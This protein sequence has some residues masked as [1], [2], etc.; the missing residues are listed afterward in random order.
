MEGASLQY[1]KGGITTMEEYLQQLKSFHGSM[2][3]GL[4]IGG[5]MVKLALRTLPKDKLYDAI[6]ETPLCL[7]D[8]IQLLTPC[9]IGNGW[10]TVLNFGRF[11]ITLYDKYSGVG[12][13]VYLD[14]IKLKKYPEVNSWYFK[15]KPKSEQDFQLLIAQIVEAE[16]QILTLQNVRVQPESL[17][18]KKIG[19][20]ADCPQCGECYPVRDGLSCR[21][22]Q[23]ESPY[24]EVETPELIEKC[25]NC[26]GKL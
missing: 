7:P 3:P 9:T 1:Q 26:A 18:R 19:P 11:A 23:G 10:L 14:S 25:Q 12:V 5:A 8:A 13:R 17:R 22:C 16:E 21:A 24:V 4:I 20:V 6:C 2:A 15:L